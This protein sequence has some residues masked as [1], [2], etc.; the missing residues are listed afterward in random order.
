MLM[1]RLDPAHRITVHER[2]RA[3]RHVRL[4]R[5]LLGRDARRLRRGR[6]REPPGDHRALRV[7]DRHRHLLP[8][9]AHPLHRPRLL[10]DRA[11][12]VPAD[13]AGPRGALGVRP[14]LRDRG[15]PGAAA[16]RATWCWPRTAPTRACATTARSASGP[17]VDWRRCK[18]TWLGTDQP[19]RRVH[20]H[21]PGERARALP[22]ARVPVR[23]AHEHVH[24]RVPRGDLAR[25]RAR[26]RV[27]GGDGRVPGGALPR[28]PAGPPP[29]HQPL[30]L[31]DLPD[32]EERD[33]ARRQRRARRR[34]RAHGALLDRLG[35]QAR[36]GG[37]DRARG[38]RSGAHGDR[39]RRPRWPRT[40]RSAGRRS[41]ASSRPRR[42][43]WSGSRTRLGTR[44]R[45]TRSRSRSA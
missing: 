6:P 20:L 21:L 14:A 13:P 9:R 31:A 23:R 27:R 43:A 28:G 42:P 36:D 22:G 3:G 29:P 12:R 17:T 10:R 26:P 1:K 32:R 24:R 25:G 16:G 33:V 38:T 37:R 19:P 8:R 7:L 5:R 11:P 41:G 44:G 2:N 40:R 35:H 34:R 45:R 18:F 4:G 30:D 39:R 15:R